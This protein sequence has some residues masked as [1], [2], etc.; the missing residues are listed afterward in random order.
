MKRGRHT[1]TNTNSPILR[2]PAWDLGVLRVV[3]GLRYHAKGVA[4][5]GSVH[6]GAALQQD[7]HDKTYDTRRTI[8]SRIDRALGCRSVS[9]TTAAFRG[10]PQPIEDCMWTRACQSQRVTRDHESSSALWKLDMRMQSVSGKEGCKMGFF[11][12]KRGV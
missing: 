8:T 7:G 5:N 12:R 6:V 11:G 10:L 3:V 2:R 9:R 4:V 1:P